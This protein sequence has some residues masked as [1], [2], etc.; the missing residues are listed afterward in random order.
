MSVTLTSVGDAGVA[1]SLFL[2]VDAADAMRGYMSL[3]LKSDNMSDVT[4]NWVQHFFL[5]GALLLL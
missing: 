3:K 4:S 2:D 5:G 1:V